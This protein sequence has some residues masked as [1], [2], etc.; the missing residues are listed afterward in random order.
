MICSLVNHNMNGCTIEISPG[1]FKEGT[2]CYFD[3]HTNRFFVEMNGEYHWYPRM[4]VCTKSDI[5]Q[6]P[7]YRL[8]F[9]FLPVE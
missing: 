3:I 1:V 8:I 5:K 7:G 9:T 4:Q 2:I 6:L